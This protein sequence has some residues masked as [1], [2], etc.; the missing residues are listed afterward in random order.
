MPRAITA[1]VLLAACGD[2][3]STLPIDAAVDAAPDVA[4]DARPDAPPDAPPVALGHHHYVID[5]MQVPT[6]NAEARDFGQDING[7]TTVDNQLGMVFGAL[8]GQGFD[9]QIS[10]TQQIDRGT[11]ITLVDLR[12]DS[13]T[14]EA[15][16]G[17]AAFVGANP[18]PAAC[19]GT[20]DLTC[21]HHLTGT[22]QFTVPTGSPTHPALAGTI[23]AGML[24]T[25]QGDLAMPI[26]AFPG[27]PAVVV[28]LL[29]ARVVASQ[30]SAAS[31]LTMK[32]A[33]AVPAAEIETKLYPAMRDGFQAAIL[34]ECGATGTPPSCG[35]AAGSSAAS[36][37]SLFDTAPKD[38][39]ISLQEIHDSSLIQSLFA[40]DVTIGGQM[41]LSVGFKATAVAATFTAP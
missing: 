26:A 11:S 28:N 14:T 41:G 20:S 36:W 30:L 15:G 29:G 3:G 24:T 8:N 2:G 22:A 10:T 40:P 38:C 39:A 16:A 32:I 25:V 35:C 13:F 27:A 19:T 5:S 12:A 4:I 37:L 33:G 23:T 21:R 18:I 7:D 34:S 31:V 1:L 6:T 9:V 17:F